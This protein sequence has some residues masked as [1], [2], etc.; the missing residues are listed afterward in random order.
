M[1][2]LKSRR[3]TLSFAAILTAILAC[4]SHA[5]RSVDAAQTKSNLPAILAQMNAASQRFTVCPSRPAPGSSSPK[6][7]TNGDADGPDLFS[8]QRLEQPRWA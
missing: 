4:T 5:I 3:I 6:P 2:V 8:T 7:S 1:S